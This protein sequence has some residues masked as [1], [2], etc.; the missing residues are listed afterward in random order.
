MNLHELTAHELV[1]LLKQKKTSVEQIYDSVVAQ[2]K[3]LDKDVKAFV[4]LFHKPE[5][6]SSAGPF[7]MPI[8]IKDKIAPTII[9]ITRRSKWSEIQP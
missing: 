3:R 6:K 7:P 4:R 1:D 8:A 5:L 2:T 9:G